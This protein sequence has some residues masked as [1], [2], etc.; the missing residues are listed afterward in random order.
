MLH[1]HTL[2]SAF[3]AGSRLANIMQGRKVLLSANHGVTV[4]TDTIAEAFD[5]LYY[6]ER[7]AEVTVKALSTQKPL[8]MIDDKVC[9]ETRENF[10]KSGI[11]AEVRSVIVDRMGHN[12]WSLQLPI[13]TH[14]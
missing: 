14:G 6:L 10:Y 1:H 12:N 5:Y 2:R 7:V 3:D 13:R 8:K 9:A 11:A 4:A